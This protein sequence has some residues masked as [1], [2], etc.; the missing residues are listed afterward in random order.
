M[1]RVLIAGEPGAGIIAAL[2]PIDGETVIEKPGKGVLRHGPRGGARK[3]PTK[4]LVFAGVTT[5]V[6]VQPRCARQTTAAT[7]C[8]RRRDRKLFSAVQGGDARHDPRARG[9]RRLDAPTDACS[10][11]SHERGR[12]CKATAEWRLA[13]ARLC[14]VSAG[15]GD[16]SWSMAATTRQ[17][18]P[19]SAISRAPLSR[20]C[21]RTGDCPRAGILPTRR[22]DATRPARSSS[23]R[24]GPNIQSGP[25]VDAWCLFSGNGP[26]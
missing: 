2:H 8:R 6:C 7:A 13:L 23:T 9:D 17:A 19:C 4:S 18:W 25:T 21:I 10:R 11:R 15:R 1:G 24:P 3:T 12:R 16:A 20:T 22:V 5:E 14:A 26:Y